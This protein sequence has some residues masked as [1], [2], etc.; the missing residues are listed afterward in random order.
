MTKSI[1]D[2]G[3]DYIAYAKY[4]VPPHDAPDEVQAE[5]WDLGWLVEED[6]E[7]AWE[8]IKFVV[9]RFAETDL[10]RSGVES[11]RTDAQRV[12]GLLAAGPLEDFLS[13]H[14]ADYIER[15]EIEARKDRRLAWALGGSL[16]VRDDR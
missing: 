1:E 12:V 14:G 13:F 5:A 9:T 15:V 8:A 10:I 16:A 6:P 3:R 2:I 7:R 4:P 11:D